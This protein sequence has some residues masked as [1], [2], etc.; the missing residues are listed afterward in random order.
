MPRSLRI[1]RS[2]E[3]R[4]GT[5][6]LTKLVLCNVEFGSTAGVD[7]D[8]SL[9]VKRSGRRILVGYDLRLM[10]DGQLWKAAYPGFDRSGTLIGLLAGAAGLVR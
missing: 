2:T 9:C 5:A 3:G 4:S 6:T 7:A 10:G 8:F 1:L